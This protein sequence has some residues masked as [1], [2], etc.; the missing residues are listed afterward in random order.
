M[1][2]K[3]LERIS[4]QEFELLSDEIKQAL[5]EHHLWMHRISMAIASRT[6]I[7]EPSF[8]EQN[9]HLHCKFGSW[10][11]N[12]LADEQ[13]Q[14]DEFDAIDE[15]H[16]KL[17]QSGRAL[18]LNLNK[19]SEFDEETYAAFLTEQREFFNAVLK[20]LEFSIVSENQFDHTTKLMNRRSVYT[21]LAHEKHRM[22]RAEDSLCCI[23]LADIDHF[24]KFNDKYGHDVGDIVLEH[25]A[26]LFNNTIRR[27]DSVARFGGEEFLFVLPDMDLSDASIALER[28]REKL[29]ST[30][31]EHQGEKLSITA[32]F[33]VTQLCRHCDINGSLKR[34]DVALYRAKDLGRNRTVCVDSRDL[35]KD[36]DRCN[37]DPD[38]EQL[39]EFITQHCTI[40][41]H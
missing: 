14:G 16:Q 27:Y 29:A 13:F 22:Q 1:L 4:Q 10:L 24:K 34:A 7:D 35:F 25:V 40:I 11:R 20:I 36:P 38:S 12:L 17:H 8:T 21:I 6:P 31:I 2:E 19:N 41:E 37:V 39:T 3:L 32:S 26:S 5:S 28:V 15:L 18:L 9:A 23:A 30:V 33:G